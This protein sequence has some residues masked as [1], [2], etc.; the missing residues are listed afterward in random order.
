MYAYIER[1]FAVTLY[2]ND[3]KKEKKKEKSPFSVWIY[4]L[5]LQLLKQSDWLTKAQGVPQSI[6]QKENACYGCIISAKQ[7]IISKVDFSLHEY[8][9]N[10]S[11]TFQTK[12]LITTHSLLL[13][14][15]TQLPPAP[16]CLP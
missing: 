16:S 9:P 2:F 14:T 4:G 6:K 8:E 3:K 10:D 13:F 15:G 7:P 11:K 12:W 5:A 1:P